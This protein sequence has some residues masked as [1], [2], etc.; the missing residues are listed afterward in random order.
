M[1]DAS[2]Y[3]AIGQTYIF[4]IGVAQVRQSYP[5]ADTMRYQVMTGP[6][7]GEADTVAIET[8]QLAP[9]IFLVSWQ[10]ADHLT[11]VHV[12]DFNTHT[13]HSCVTMPDGTFRRITSKMWRADQ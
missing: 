2:N 8:E 11:V 6:R 10:E 3:P 5:A 7:A 9:G 12:E 4:D 1:S 13:F